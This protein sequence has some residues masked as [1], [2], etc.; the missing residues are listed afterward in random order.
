MSGQPTENNPQNV[1]AGQ[2][3]AGQ[4]TA[5]NIPFVQAPV[6]FEANKINNLFKWPEQAKDLMQKAGQQEI[7][8]TQAAQAQQNTD[9]FANVASNVAAVNKDSSAA[10]TDT[11][12]IN[13]VKSAQAAVESKSTSDQN[14][15]EKAYE[16]DLANQNA[17]VQTKNESLKLLNENYNTIQ[18]SFKSL[19]ASA[20]KSILDSERQLAETMRRRE[21]NR[22]Q[23]I[24]NQLQWQ[25]EV[26]RFSGYGL[27]DNMSAFIA[28]KLM[29]FVWKYDEETLD[30]FAK[31]QT[32][33]S[34]LREER[35]NLNNSVYSL[36]TNYVKQK[37]ELFLQAKQAEN[38]AKYMVD[39][40]SDYINSLKQDIIIKA[41]EK[42]IELQQKLYKDI[43]D[44]LS[45]ANRTLTSEVKRIESEQTIAR[46]AVTNAISD[47][48]IVH[49]T[50]EQKRKYASMIG[51]TEAG[52]MNLSKTAIESSIANILKSTKGDILKT[53]ELAMQVMELLNHWVDIDTAMKTVFEK[54]GM[55]SNYI[56]AKY[57]QA[58]TTNG[59][60]YK[61]QE[62]AQAVADKLSAEWGYEKVEVYSHAK[63]FGIKATKK[64]WTTVDSLGLFNEWKIASDWLSFDTQLQTDSFN[65]Q[66]STDVLADNTKIKTSNGGWTPTSQTTTKTNLKTFETVSWITFT[67]QPTN[68]VQ[69]LEAELNNITYELKP[70]NTSNKTQNRENK[71]YNSNIQKLNDKK[72][73]E[74]KEKIEKAK[75]IDEVNWIINNHI[76]WMIQSAKNKQS[77]WIREGLVKKDLQKE[78]YEKVMN[79]FLKNHKD[80]VDRWVTVSS[81]PGYSNDTSTVKLKKEALREALWLSANAWFISDAKFKEF[82]K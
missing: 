15:V 65:I 8:K 17:I 25:N 59:A 68:I 22:Q 56:K 49:W 2:T 71:V 18:E 35:K 14:L 47:G 21:E 48:S 36:V 7:L 52:I 72:K 29:N 78:F 28:G 16:R 64:D 9:A 58:T 69:L 10:A 1:Q 33:T 82:I 42:N 20:D 6:N 43:D 31:W 41:K 51:T 80:L 11:T 67:E 76:E 50:P 63:W 55:W 39:G 60:Y 77:E 23:A 73:R 46:Q 61:T 30:I 45:M 27:S 13:A 44:R 70:T 4:Q 12:G 75:I 38:M 62:E 53:P 24:D 34:S 66:T 74:L 26:A 79:D 40:K 5:N 19:G 54:N 3:Q 32:L 37:D 57:W 81:I